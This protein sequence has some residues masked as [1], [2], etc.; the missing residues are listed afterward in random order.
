MLQIKGDQAFDLASIRGQALQSFFE[1]FGQL[2]EGAFVV[3]RDS[4]V[5]WANARY[6]AFIGLE[7]DRPVV[8]QHIS[9]V[10]PTTRMPE[11]V[12]TGR[13]IP[14]DVIEVNNR[15]AVVSRFPIKNDEQEVIGGFCFVL[16]DEI[17]PLRP[18]LARIQ[19][20]QSE[21][22]RT[23]SKLNQLRR[24]KYEFSH[25]V[26]SSPQAAQV[27]RSA[28]Q[29]AA[30]D[31][32]V[33]LLGETG[34]GKEMVAQGI[35]AASRR[36]RQNF[37][38]V[39]VAAIPEELMEAEFFGSAPGAYTGAHPKGR[40]GKMMLADKGT[41]FLDEIG[42]M[43]MR[44]QV[45][46]LRALQEREIEPIG[47]NT[48]IPLDLR[49]IAATSRDL[50]QLVETGQFRA[51]LYYRLSVVPIQIPPLRE[52]LEDLPELVDLLLA[53]LCATLGMREKDVAPDALARLARFGWPGNVR[54]LR[55]VLERACV[56][57][58]DASELR[59]EHMLLNDG[60]RPAAVA[61]STATVA[62]ARHDLHAAVNETEQK[63][64]L[65]ALQ[66]TRGNKL[67]A[68]RLLGISRSTLYN[69]LKQM[70]LER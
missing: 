55:N 2:A 38:G 45:K 16:F 59:A 42:D 70:A 41:L 69:K 5:I 61:A 49:V 57:S 51:D 68:A 37:I 56:V 21:L 15:W 54:E 26:G 43:P 48:V 64:L 23:R 58:G 35:H 65:H 27:R 50:R 33:L 53:E 29:V 39:N 19:Q 13:S 11:V 46:L 1:L 34:T 4:K 62:P 20:L 47:G 52:R 22:E 9:T 25:F 67:L 66:E 32:T 7:P 30:T 24:T 44:I 6:L 40:T 10:V 14:F 18:M 17:D 12:E 63:A 60:A 36:A 31:S 3:D 8:G 28:R